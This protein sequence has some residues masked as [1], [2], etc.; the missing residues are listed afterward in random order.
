[1]ECLNGERGR[2][3]REGEGEGGEGE[4]GG[5]REREREKEKSGF[6]AWSL[7]SLGPES[8]MWALRAERL[9]I[10]HLSPWK[11]QLWDRNFVGPCDTCLACSLEGA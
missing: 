5:E 10:C 11:A 3:E 6:R 7:E 2:R 1:V 8:G 9:V 4:G